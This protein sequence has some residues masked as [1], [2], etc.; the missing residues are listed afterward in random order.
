MFLLVISLLQHHRVDDKA[1]N[2]PIILVIGDRLHASAGTVARVAVVGVAWGKDA[3][4]LDMSTHHFQHPVVV[5]MPR[6]PIAVL[7]LAPFDRHI[8]CHCQGQ[9][10]QLE[11][12]SMSSTKKNT[13]KPEIMAIAGRSV[14]MNTWL[15][16]IDL[17]QCDCEVD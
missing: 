4:L 6:V 10:R 9:V 13:P 3:E 14:H 11:L 1:R 2:L 12:I 16:F 15:I 17:P 8:S 5:S 7:G